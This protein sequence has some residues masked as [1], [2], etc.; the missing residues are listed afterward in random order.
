[1]TATI[2]K[3]WKNEYFQTAVVVALI[4]AVI[5]GFWFGSQLVLNTKIPPAL[6]VISGSMCIP[7]DG[8][9]DGWAHPFDQTLHVGDIIVIQGVDPKD[10]NANYPNSDIIVYQ[11]PWYPTDPDAKIV[12][13]IVAK[14]EI[15]GTLYFY[16]KGDGNGADKW[17]NTPDRSEYDPWSPV[18][19]NLIYGKVVMRIPWIGHIAI[20]MHKVL[21]VNSSFIGI[22]II[23]ILIILL[24][25]IEFV[26]PIFRHRKV[27]TDQRKA[28]ESTLQMY[29]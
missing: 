4:V 5:F 25:L 10:L 14:E 20:F 1:M 9:C 27:P 29:L 11:N 12:H 23:I 22:P 21:G 7:Y 18:P 2:K 24:I 28:V 6:A 17:P 8:A 26:L 3:L 15:N 19:A 13:R 16:T